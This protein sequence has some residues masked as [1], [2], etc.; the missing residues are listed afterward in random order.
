LTSNNLATNQPIEVGALMGDNSTQLQFVIARSNTPTAS[1]P[2]TH[3]R[4]VMP[5]DGIPNLGP[6]EYFTYNSPPPGGHAIAAGCNGTA[7]YSVF[8]PS[9]P[10]F[11]TSPGPA[12]IYFDDNNNRLT[13]PLIRQQPSVAAADGGN[14]SFFVSD[15]DSD[16][17]T[18]PN[19]FGT[20][21]AGPHAAAIAALVLQAHGGPH[22]VTPTQMSTILHQTAFPHDLD[23]FFASGTATTTN[24]GTVTVR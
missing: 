21:A 15:S 19:F 10:E 9:I 7:A 1:Q 16:I 22:S 2:A 6:N 4:W 13:P 18:N 14:T 20:S 3:V 24:G 12:T 8:R 17:D 23:P 5:G 11:Y